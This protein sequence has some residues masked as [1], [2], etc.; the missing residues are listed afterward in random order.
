MAAH[1]HLLIVE[2]VD[3][4]RI[5]LKTLLEQH[6]SDWKISDAAHLWEAQERIL[7]QRPDLILLDELL[8]G[9][10]LT[11]GLKLFKE[12]GIPVIV[13]TGSEVPEGDFRVAKPQLEEYSRKDEARFL[14]VLERHLTTLK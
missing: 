3:E 5:F 14:K 10:T 9:E 12:S 13:M 11:D 7:T 2:D 1:R 8:P 4:M 6:W